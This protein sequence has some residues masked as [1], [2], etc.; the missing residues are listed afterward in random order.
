MRP[1]FYERFA[2]AIRRRLAPNT[3]LHLKQLA[4]AINVSDDTLV[5]WSRGQTR[6]TAEALGN[7]AEFFRK[8]GDK[9]FLAEIYGDLVPPIGPDLTQLRAI[10]QEAS[11]QLSAAEAMPSDVCYWVT[12]DGAMHHAPAGHREFARRILRFPAHLDSDYS[13]YAMRTLGWIA[14][15]MRSNE[16]SAVI[17]YARDSIDPLAAARLCEYLLSQSKRGLE[18]AHRFV[19]IDRHWVAAA[20]TDA[21]TAADALA[22]AARI[23]TS[24]A[25]WDVTRHSLEAAR[26]PIFEEL[27]K[28]YNNAEPLWA[29]ALRLGISAS[30]SVLR[31]EEGN[32][33]SLM[34]GPGLGLR[35]EKRVGRNVMEWANT[36][37]AKVVRD[38]SIAARQQPVYQHNDVPI[39]GMRCRY[40]TLALPDGEAGGPG[41]V[42]IA[43]HIISKELI[44][45]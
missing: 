26:R 36:G 29:A 10:I 13:I 20:R 37:Y 5:R 9:S 30:C 7:L 2:D 24:G 17:R 44:T 39:D 12:D 38:R 14:L 18:S 25:K 27:L 45:A 15:T 34:V 11:R 4:G 22:Q 32:V 19:D 35:P 16:T 42:F 6:I 21:V 23:A 3:G 41:T 31:V 28:S 33:T 1:E 43:S 8:R 40:E